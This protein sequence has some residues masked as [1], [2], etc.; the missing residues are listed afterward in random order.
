MNKS[1]L[2]RIEKPFIYILQVFY[3]RL[4]KSL[5]YQ[6]TAVIMFYKPSIMP[7]EL[8]NIK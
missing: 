1:S 2:Q 3:G 8:L 4:M 5:I 6:S 7:I